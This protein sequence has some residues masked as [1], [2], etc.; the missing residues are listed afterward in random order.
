M[1]RLE[2]DEKRKNITYKHT[3]VIVDERCV[4]FII[5]DSWG[6]GFEDTSRAVCGKDLPPDSDS[7]A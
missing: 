6:D 4:D 1:N 7:S 3:R 2:R 5:R